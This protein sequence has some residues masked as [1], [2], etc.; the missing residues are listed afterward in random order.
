MKWSS[1]VSDN[2]SISEAVAECASRIRRE[3]GGQAPDLLVAFVSEHHAPAY[4]QVPSLIR[5]NLPGGMLIGCSGGGVIGDGKEVEHRPGFAITGVHLPDVELATFH[6]DDQA[7]PDGDAAP[8]AWEALVTVPADKDPKFLLLADP[9]SVRGEHLL[10]GLDYA[11]P[12]SVKIGGLA[13]GAHQPGGNA[14]YLSD[15]IYTSGVVGVAMHGDIEVD[16]VV[17]QGCRPIGRTMHV[18]ACRHNLLLEL[19]GQT[20]FEV[21]KEIFEELTERDRELAHHS[22]FLGIVMDELGDSPQQGDFL[23]RNVVGADPQKGALA[24]GEMLKEGQTVQFH[25]RDAHTSAQDLDAMLSQFAG[26]GPIHEEAGALLFSCLGR[27]ANLYGRP[28]HD[29]DMFRERVGH[30]PL[31]GFFC[32]GEIGPVGGSTFL[33]GYTSSFGIFRPRYAE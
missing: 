24:I 17:A 8:D 23:I 15:E 16:T 20:P 21:L 26:L 2:T 19:D 22:L 11:Y 32:N 12:R 1:A 9:F 18:T 3:L 28:D 6:I 33:H 25:L 30:I 4:E 13:S 14:L 31:T 7:L 29:T 10:M 27:G 5:E